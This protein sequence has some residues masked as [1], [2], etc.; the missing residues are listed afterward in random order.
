MAAE[1]GPPTVYGKPFTLLEDTQKT[2]FIY[3]NGS[4]VPHPMTIAEFRESC[5]VTELPQKVKQMTRYEVRAPV[6][7]EI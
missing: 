1:R 6:G 2:T 5:E 4:W 7:M 3:K